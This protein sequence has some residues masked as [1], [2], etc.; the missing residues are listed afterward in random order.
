MTVSFPKLRA[1]WTVLAMSANPPPSFR[2]RKITST[3]ARPGPDEVCLVI[4]SPEA[5]ALVNSLHPRPPVIVTRFAEINRA[6]LLETKPDCVVM[7]LMRPTFD[8]PQGL[9][10]LA[11]IGFCGRICV[12]T[13][14]LPN[15]RMVETELRALAEGIEFHLIE[16]PQL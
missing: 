9:A 7:P 2:A 4:D 8:A 5:N 13:G 1:P 12:V 11:A 14:P 6:M 10:L 16:F 15:R 3:S